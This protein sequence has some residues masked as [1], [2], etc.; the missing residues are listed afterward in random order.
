VLPA[1]R[2][3]NKLLESDPVDPAQFAA[4]RAELDGK[5]EQFPMSYPNRDDVIA[6]QHAIEVG[7]VCAGGKGGEG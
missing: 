6:P 7:G 2:I 1:L 3:L 5:K 4:W